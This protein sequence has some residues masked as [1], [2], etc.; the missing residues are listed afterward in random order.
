MTFNM[1]AAKQAGY[2]DKEIEDFLSKNEGKKEPVKQE[3]KFNVE[4][5]KKAGYSD[6]E[7]EQFL[8][9]NKPKIEEKPKLNEPFTIKGAAAQFGAGLGGGAGGLGPDIA[10]MVE[11]F[12]SLSSKLA[13]IPAFDPLSNVAKGLSDLTKSTG[14]KGTEQLTQEFA[15]QEPQNS[16]ERILRTG[17]QF[18][19]QEFLIGTALGG[20]PG[21]LAGGIHGTASGLL[22]GGLKEAGVPDEW[23]LGLTAL[24]TLSPI[25]ARE[26]WPKL[27]QKFKA[28]ASFNEAKQAVLPEGLKFSGG[29]PPPPGGGA[30]PK[31]GPGTVF[32]EAKGAFEEKE[33]IIDLLKEK[34]VEPVPLKIKPEIPTLTEQGRSLKGR[35]KEELTHKP[36]L[37]ELP[38]VA[39]EGADTAELGQSISKQA[40][41]TEAQAGR[42]ISN[43]IKEVRDKEIANYQELYKKADEVTPTHYDTF[44][45]MAQKNE[46]RIFRLEQ[47][48]K[49]NAAEE[50]V[51]QDAL[52]LRKIIGEPNA[53][54]EANAK[55]LMKQANS[56]SKKVN[57]EAQYA[58]A[59]NEVKTIVREMNEGVINSLKVH[60]KDAEAVIKA[61]RAYAKFADRFMGDEITPYTERKILNPESLIRKAVSDEGTYRA[62]KDVFASRDLPLINKLDRA[63]S[64]SR[65]GKY[66]KEPSKVGSKEYTKDL[67]NLQELIGKDKATKLD[68]ELRQIQLNQEK[69]L[70]QHEFSEQRKLGRQKKPLGRKQLFERKLEQAAV[71]KEYQASAEGGGNIPTKKV[72]RKPKPLNKVPKPLAKTPEQIDKLMNS[73][74]GIRQLRDEL[75]RKGNPEEFERLKEIKLEEIFREG[76]FGEKK[77]T[78]TDLQR[79]IDKDHEVLKEL[80]SEEE[81][82]Q[83]YKVSAK[84]GKQELTQEIVKDVLKAAGKMT[85]QS[86]GLGKILKLLP[87]KHV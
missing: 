69:L 48:P 80:L 36:T 20:A 60:G 72:E 44:P 42:D 25:A 46:D 70:R 29:E 62:V 84:A 3:K 67:K 74:S 9:K 2:S 38:K 63:V 58:G 5:A 34:P 22:Y 83:L 59:K 52:T 32:P 61:D 37:E 68:H 21:A 26:L 24:V 43:A 12:A 75:R 51:Y 27:V 79:I 57:H 64:E 45:E 39:V 76:G 65:M 85:L 1:Q 73:R 53:L 86:L 66:Y 17:G 78:G 49:R 11:P 50:A 31:I 10:N 87:L 47:I 35:V 6:K 13:G 4:A 16:A 18:G 23:A 40:F 7:I 41:E 81:V 14:A 8:A 54:E 71:P 30:P 19:G 82:S 33:R 77:I 15:A 56:F 55:V 28:G